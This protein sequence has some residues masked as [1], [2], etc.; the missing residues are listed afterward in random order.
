L[1]VRDEHWADAARTRFTAQPLKRLRHRVRELAGRRDI[2]TFRIQ[3]GSDGSLID[4]QNDL[5]RYVVEV[6]R[7]AER[8][9]F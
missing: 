9:L 3:G 4:P 7:P 5:P 1:Q 8:R 2:G 6:V